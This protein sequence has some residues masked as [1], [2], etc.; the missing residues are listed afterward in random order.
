LE[1][2]F[3]LKEGKVK[4]VT[5]METIFAFFSFLLTYFTFLK[6]VHKNNE[7]YRFLLEFEDI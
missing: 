2:M 4:F 3:S 7:S 6:V 1:I 5:K